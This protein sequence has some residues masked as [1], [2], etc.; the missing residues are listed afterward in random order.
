VIVVDTSVIYALLDRND[1]N[2]GQAAEWYLASTPTLA[3][4]PLI[5]AEVDHLAGTR[6]GP[7]AQ[8]A[9]RRDV[10]AGAY[11]ISWWSRAA[12]ESVEIAERYDDLGVGL[13]DASLVALA[14]R[15]NVVDIATFDERHFRAMRPAKGGNA[16]RLLPSD[17]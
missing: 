9:F 14:A 11:E 8:T 7:G 10:V 3:T 1:R 5:L 17:Q 2:H 4:T 13:A 16:F 15:L 6:A 12:N